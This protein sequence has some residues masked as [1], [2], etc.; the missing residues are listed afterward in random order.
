MRTD[1]I[2]VTM[3]C[4]TVNTGDEPKRGNT[5]IR[6]MMY[7]N[8]ARVSHCLAAFSG[9]NPSTTAN[10]SNGWMGM[11]LKTARETLMTMT[12]WRMSVTT[13]GMGRN[14][15][16]REQ[17]TDKRM[18]A[19]AP[20]SDINAASL[21]GLRKLNGSKR[22]GLPQPNPT[23]NMRIVPTGSRCASGLNDSRPS[24]R[25]FGSPSRSATHAWANSWIVMADKSPIIPMTKEIGLL[26]RELSMWYSISLS[27]TNAKWQTS[28]FFEN[29][30]IHM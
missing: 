19:V 26:K 4:T 23:R 5:K 1:K 21:R 27:M 11:R 10:P 29:Y 13:Y 16:R 12:D 28:F 20:A 3:R 8:D 14:R 30:G 9:K 17:M 25:G 24:S 7:P 6:S 18:F 15:N 2:V 22:T